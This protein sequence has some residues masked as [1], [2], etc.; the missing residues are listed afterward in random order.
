MTSP[1]WF[2]ETAI[3]GG[4]GRRIGKAAAATVATILVVGL[5]WRAPELWLFHGFATWKTHEIQHQLQMV[6]QMTH[7]KPQAPKPSGP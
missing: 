4:F 7:A 2:F 1:W 5:V 3:D 6:E